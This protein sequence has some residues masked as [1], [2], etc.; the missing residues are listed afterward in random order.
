MKLT[1]RCQISL[2]RPEFAAHC[3]AGRKDASMKTKPHRIPGLLAL[4]IVACLALLPPF[5]RANPPEVKVVFQAFWW[6]CLNRNY[7]TDPDGTGGWYTYLAKLCPRLRDLGFDGIWIP[8]PCKAANGRFGMGYDLFDHYDLGQKFQHGTT[9]TRFGDQDAFL[10]LVA[11]AHACGL[12]VYP[13]IVLNHLSGGSEDPA[14]EGNRFKTFQ[15]RGFAGPTAGRWPKGRLD[16]HPNP[17]H[18]S[19]GDEWRQEM[20]GPDVCYRGRCCDR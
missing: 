19:G 16:F 20:F 10:R 4:S 2:D 17:H 8:S 15:Y 7:Q 3:R 1:A 13:D 14:A 9:S 18:G 11:V 5:A 6:D 12:E